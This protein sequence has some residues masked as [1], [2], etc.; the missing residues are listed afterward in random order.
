[1]LLHKA[2]AFLLRKSIK[3]RDAYDAMDLIERGATLKGNLNS[4]L[5]DMLYGEFESGRLQERIKQVDR[6]VVARS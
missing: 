5:A 4:Y 1:M 2:E 6:G 3:A